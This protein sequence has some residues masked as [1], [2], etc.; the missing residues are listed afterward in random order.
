MDIIRQIICSL[1]VLMIYLANN[2]DQWLPET[3]KPNLKMIVF[4]IFMLNFLAAT[5]DIVVD[6][7]SLTMLKKRVLS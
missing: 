5:Q 1:A 4:V 7:W 3:E 6:G 2:I